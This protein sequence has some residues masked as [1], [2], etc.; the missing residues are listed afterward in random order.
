M[1]TWSQ[2]RV[3]II[4]INN[5]QDRGVAPPLATGGFPSFHSCFEE[6]KK[7]AA[8]K[9]FPLYFSKQLF[10]SGCVTREWEIKNKGYA[11]GIN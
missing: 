1:G 4:L 3:P 9:H 11:C 10:L 8:L 2:L 7:L 5:P 6:W